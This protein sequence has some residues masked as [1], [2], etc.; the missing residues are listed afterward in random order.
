M[1]LPRFPGSGRPGGP[2]EGTEDQTDELSVAEAHRLDLLAL[3]REV[4]HVRR[5]LG[6]RAAA[7]T[8]R[9]LARALDD[10]RRE[11]VQ[12]RLEGGDGG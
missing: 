9:V 7:R 5:T 2:N 3:D 6:P 1:G 11:R 10:R 4:E 12:R 8:R